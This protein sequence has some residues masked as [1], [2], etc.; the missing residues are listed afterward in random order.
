[1]HG[2][3]NPF[4]FRDCAM[5]HLFPFV[6]HWPGR[7]WTGDLCYSF[8]STRVHMFDVW[9]I[10]SHMHTYAHN[11]ALA[12]KKTDRVRPRAKDVQRAIRR[13][14]SARARAGGE[15]CVLL[16]WPYVYTNWACM[17]RQPIA[18][19]Q[20]SAGGRVSSPAHTHYNVPKMCIMIVWPP[21]NNVHTQTR[22]LIAYD[23]IR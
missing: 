11:C 15:V 7:A 12:Q 1:M 13:D 4:G 19:S 14:Q 8:N 10:V 18:C 16:L 23:Q 22:S 3:W 2:A 6:A 20:M 17:Q 21:N 5:L 9:F